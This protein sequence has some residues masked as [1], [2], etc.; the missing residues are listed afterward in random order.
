MY[1]I[2]IINGS[3]FGAA[4]NCLNQVYCLEVYILQ[5]EQHS[6][7]VHR[8]CDVLELSAKYVDYYV[9]YHSKKDTV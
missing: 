6:E 7:N 4:V 1:I 2:K 3:T 5:D 8:D 9:A